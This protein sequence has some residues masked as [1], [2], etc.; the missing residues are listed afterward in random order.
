MSVN[1]IFKSSNIQRPFARHTGYICCGLRV[2]IGCGAD[3]VVKKK[4]YF[5]LAGN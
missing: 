5:Q 3:A 1:V 4:Q 2:L